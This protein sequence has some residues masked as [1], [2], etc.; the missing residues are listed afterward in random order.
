MGPGILFLGAK[1]CENEKK[2][3]GNSLLLYS[4]ISEKSVNFF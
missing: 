1:F 2:K 4:E 3:K